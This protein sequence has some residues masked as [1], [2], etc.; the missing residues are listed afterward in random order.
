MSPIG[1]FVPPVVQPVTPPPPDSYRIGRN[2]GIAVGRAQMVGELGLGEL[3]RI[4]ERPTNSAEPWRWM[5]TFDGKPRTYRTLAAAKGAR[6]QVQAA[7]DKHRI[8]MEVA[9]QR[10]PVG[11]WEVIT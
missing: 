11:Q 3:Y 8:P 5:G 1:E 7:Y 4:V 9:V 2:D 6:T 10:A